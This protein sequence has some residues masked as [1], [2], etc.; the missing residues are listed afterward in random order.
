MSK[1]Y[2]YPVEQKNTFLEEITE[3]DVVETGFQKPTVEV[4]AESS[5]ITLSIRSLYP[6]RL[7]YEGR[8]SGKLYEWAE[9]GSVVDVHVE[10][11]PYLLEKRLG[12]GGCCGAS[13]EANKLFERL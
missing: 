5:I 10:D 7:K 6:A 8:V 2:T 13:S 3:K 1:K 4:V 9:A 12:S 11:A